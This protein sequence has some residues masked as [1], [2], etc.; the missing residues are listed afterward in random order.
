MGNN[1]RIVRDVL[2]GYIEFDELDRQVL[3]LPVVQRLRYIRQNDVAYLVYPSLNTSRFEHSLGVMHLAGKVAEAALENSPQAD[4][5]LGQLARHYPS[6]ADSPGDSFVRAARWYG[7]LH[8]IGHLPLS[9]LTEH[10]LKARTSEL[11]PDQSDFGKLHEA[12]GAWLTMENRELGLALDREPGA[13]ALVKQLLAVKELAFD[14]RQHLLQPLKDIVDSDL[15]VDRLDSV[16]RDGLAAGGDIGRYDSARLIR[17]AVLVDHDDQWRVLFTTHALSSIEG[18]LTERVKVH[19]WIHYQPKV[20]AFKNAVR[21]C[22]EHVVADRGLDSWHASTYVDHPGY[23][24]DGWLINEIN[25][26]PAGGSRKLEWARAAMLQRVSTARPLWKRGD[27]FRHLSDDVAE[28]RDTF[29]RLNRPHYPILNR[30][31]HVLEELE[32]RLNDGRRETEYLLWKTP[33][34]PF[35]TLTSTHGNDTP[36][37][38]GTPIGRQRVLEHRTLS[39]VLLT[40]ISKVVESLWSVHVAEPAYGVT[41]LGDPEVLDKDAS[42]ADLRDHFIAVTSGFLKEIYPG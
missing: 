19:R 27:E 39:P 14:D 32:D 36:E 29:R 37:L 30:L 11:Y 24:D 12:A 22:I 35:E 5:Y 23:L 42:I 33:L 40:D 4:H 3:D 13:A 25:A 38:E 9:H 41:L 2:Y 16:A 6:T 7:L 21:I 20:V 10:T 26:L 31:G 15:D 34:R 17:A 18:L 8:D 28:T 1:R